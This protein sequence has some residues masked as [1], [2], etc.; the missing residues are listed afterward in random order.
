MIFNDFII[1]SLKSNGLLLQLDEIQCL[2][3]L[4]KIKSRKAFQL[5]ILEKTPDSELQLMFEYI[6][7]HFPEIKLGKD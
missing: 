5:K 3:V 2:S 6:A 4:Q 1:M 7:Q